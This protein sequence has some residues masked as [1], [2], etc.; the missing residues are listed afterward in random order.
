MSLVSAD[1]R[2]DFRQRVIDNVAAVPRHGGIP[3]EVQQ[4]PRVY[5]VLPSAKRPCQ[6]TSRGLH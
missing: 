6:T 1:E 5:S 4:H 2:R 3:R